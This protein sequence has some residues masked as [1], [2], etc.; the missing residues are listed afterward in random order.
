MK[1]SYLERSLWH[2]DDVAPANLYVWLSAV[3][4]SS[5][6]YWVPP[7][8]LALATSEHRVVLACE[9]G[10]PSRHRNGLYSGHPRYDREGSWPRHGSHHRDS[11]RV[12]L[13]DEHRDLG[14]T[15][16]LT[17]TQTRGNYVR[18]L[19]R[20]ASGDLEPT[21]KW[22]VDA[23]VCFDAVLRGQLFF[24]VHTHFK[25][26]ARSQTRSGLWRTAHLSRHALR[27]TTRSAHRHDRRQRDQ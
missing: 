3:R 22:E 6:R 18:D 2:E 10:K 14:L 17:L 9:R 12:A 13:G 4:D 24:T 1:G 21:K 16:N 11:K 8:L 19:A 7:H 15:K 20:C 26:V 25:Q 5:H 27:A 23:S